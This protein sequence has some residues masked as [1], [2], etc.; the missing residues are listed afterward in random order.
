VA[1]ARGALANGGFPVI[2]AVG[3][4]DVAAETKCPAVSTWGLLAMALLMLSA[5]TIVLRN[6]RR[7]PA[8]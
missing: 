4:W 3:G 1:Q 6:R 8:T 2:P 5:A 7:E